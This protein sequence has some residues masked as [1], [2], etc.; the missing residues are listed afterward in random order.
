[1]SVARVRR[2]VGVIGHGYSDGDGDGF[3]GK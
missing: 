2:A 3:G 1:M